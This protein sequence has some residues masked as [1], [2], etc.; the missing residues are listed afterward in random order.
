MSTSVWEG[1]TSLKDGAPKDNSAQLK[2]CV[3]ILKLICNLSEIQ[4]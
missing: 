4:V 3:H 2:L 1:K